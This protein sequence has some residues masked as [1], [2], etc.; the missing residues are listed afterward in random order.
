MDFYKEAFNK[1]NNEES[2]KEKVRNFKRNR[3][4]ANCSRLAHVS[5]HERN[6]PPREGHRDQCPV[7]C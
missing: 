6:R 5:A 4:V 2:R 1:F 7:R 3:Q